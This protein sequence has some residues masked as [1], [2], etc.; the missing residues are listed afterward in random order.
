MT[1][2][3]V[4]TLPPVSRAYAETRATQVALLAD[5]VA[6][7]TGTVLVAGDLNL[8]RHSPAIREG[9]GAGSDHRPVVADL[10]ISPSASITSAALSTPMTR[11]SGRSSNRTLPSTRRSASSP[12]QPSHR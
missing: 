3:A 8:T 1:V 4:H 9:D 12:L 10:V 6:A 2:W 7:E 5:R 11:S